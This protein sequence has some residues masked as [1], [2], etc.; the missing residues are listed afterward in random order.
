MCRASRMRYKKCDN[1]ARSCRPSL[2]ES[3]A[4]S[5]VAWPMLVMKQNIATAELKW[6]INRSKANSYGCGAPAR[7]RTCSSELDV[8]RIKACTCTSSD[9]ATADDV[10]AHVSRLGRAL[11][12]VFRYL[13]FCLVRLVPLHHHSYRVLNHVTQMLSTRSHLIVN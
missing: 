8:D 5:C 12:L 4:L 2:E 1:L 13:H 6:Q 7:E 9:K 10:G 11:V 3:M